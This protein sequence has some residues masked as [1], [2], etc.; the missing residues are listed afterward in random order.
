M[1][2]PFR[3]AFVSLR[4]NKMRSALTM[5]GIVI[6]VSAVVAVVSLMQG[7]RGLAE[8]ALEKLGT[9]VLSVRPVQEYDLTP[10]EYKKVKSRDM[11]MDDM[12]ALSEALPSVVLA[13]TPIRYTYGDI[14]HGGR[15]VEQSIMMTDE[16]YLEQNKFDLT[17]G[18][19]FVSSDMRLRAKATIIGQGLINKLE[20]R[21]NPIGQF[22]SFQ[23]MSLEII[24]VLEEL[25]VNVVQNMD[26]IM[27]IP[28]TTGMATLPDNLRRQLGFQV[29][30]EQR[31]DALEVEDTA[32]DA[33]RRIRGVKPG[34]I[35]GFKIRSMKREADSYNTFMAAITGVG[36]G[37]VGIALLVGGIGVMNIM[38]VSV[39]ERTREI[40]VRKAVGAKRRHIKAQFLVEAALLCLLG[41]ALGILLGYAVGT[42]LCKLLFNQFHGI[43]IWAFITGFG[44]PALIGI[45]FGY[46]PASKASK[47]D[48]IESM[49]YE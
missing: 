2:E 24:G 23:N 20:I 32:R 8:V 1:L 17:F 35:E 4:A 34:E 46:Y 29:R 21:G 40:G 49:R 30:Y 3:S 37:M 27:F 38:L 48:P 18:R 15:S 6:G 43:P 36:G 44:A 11:T 41:G 26:D 14:S 5:L 13:F 9:N 10:E 45:A 39:T 42:L 16:T 47:L 25:G 22:I 12:R 33:L 28:I 31:L 7:F 19:N